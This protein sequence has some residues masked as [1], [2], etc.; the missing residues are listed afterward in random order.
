MTAVIYLDAQAMH[1]VIGGEWHRLTGAPEPGQAITT[2]CGISETATFL[3][4]G[5]RR[6]RGIPRQCDHCDAIYRRDH[7]IPPRQDRIGRR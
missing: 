7:G 4:L 1:P 5:E 3:P 6:S 2:L